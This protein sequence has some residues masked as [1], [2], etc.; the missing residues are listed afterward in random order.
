MENYDVAVLG[1]GVGGY[2][3]AIR[4]ALRGAKT[5]CI[6]AATL[7]GTCLNRGCIPTKAMLYAGRLCDLAAEAAAFG[8]R[9]GK[10]EIDGGTLME[11]VARTVAELRKGLEHLLKFRKIEMIRGR[12]RLLSPDTLEVESGSGQRRI[13]K[14]R[15]IILATGS[16]PARPDFFPWNSGRILTTDDATT[17]KEL[18]EST[19]IVGG[20]VIGCE[21]A[22]F[23]SALG[24]P[25]TVVETLDRLL[26]TFDE[27]ASRAVRRSLLK[28][29]VAVHTG[30]K[31]VA[32][33]AGKEGIVAELENGRTI[34][35]ASVLVAIGRVPNTEDIGLENAGVRTQ[36][37]IIPV[38][39]RC[40]TSVEGIYAVGDVA[41]TRQ[42]AHLA[43]RMGIVAADNATGHPTTDPRTVVPAAVFTRPEI[44]AVGLG[45]KEAR[46][47]YG[48]VRT[49]KFPYSA[50]G[51][52]RIS[53]ETDGMVKIS[54][55]EKT[56][57][58]IG[59]L[60]IGP[61][62]AEVIQEIALAMRRN[63]T[64]ADIAETIHAHPTFVEAVCEAAEVW[65]GFPVHTLGEERRRR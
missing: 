45:E 17:A 53:R 7:G 9:L 52:A 11:Y 44:A 28:R 3:A 12:G 32:V 41:E 30:S 37:G 5:C 64:V 25:T 23:Y 31:I 55:R 49:S 40:R 56:G 63:L 22:T 2:S 59:A 34:E 1:S 6:E 10:A 4:A 51:K 36:N 29:K 24:I 46:E 58:I 60:V 61:N 33:R 54:A 39:E 50:S 20:G 35:A 21:F 48:D 43:A 16:R 13:V 27:E 14:A 38:D 62:A 47:R 15:S 19:L 8:I 57:E 18:P 26:P 65:Q 42:Y